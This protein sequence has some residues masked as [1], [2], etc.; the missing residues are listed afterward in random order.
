MNIYSK[1]FV[2][3]YVMIVFVATQFDQFR[4]MNINPKKLAL[5]V[6]FCFWVNMYL[7]SVI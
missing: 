6:T 4:N 1:T 3:D 7:S 5:V 2:K